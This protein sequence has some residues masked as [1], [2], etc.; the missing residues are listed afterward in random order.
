M[1]ARI[2]TAEVEDIFA[3]IDARDAR[4]AQSRKARGQA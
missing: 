3:L 1:I 4:L 2:A